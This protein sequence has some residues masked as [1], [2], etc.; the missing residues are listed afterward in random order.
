MHPKLTEEELAALKAT[1]SDNEWNQVCLEIKTTRGG[2]YPPDW[3]PVMMASGL[4]E[5]IA[6]GWASPRT[7]EI[8][9]E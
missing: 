3:W 4:A 1:C 6:K 7:A 9:I 8:Q 2:A 5:S